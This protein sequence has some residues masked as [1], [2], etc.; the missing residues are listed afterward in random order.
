MKT[1]FNYIAKPYQALEH[2]SL[3]HKP[4]LWETKWLLAVTLSG[5]LSL[6]ALLLSV[7]SSSY[8]IL[9]LP[10]V[11]AIISAIAL[12]YW[13][14]KAIV[15]NGDTSNVFITR[16]T[17]RNQFLVYYGCI[18]S[19]ALPT[20][21]VIGLNSFEFVDSHNGEYTYWY[22]ED[23]NAINFFILKTIISGMLLAIL[24]QLVKGIGLKKILQAIAVYAI[25]WVALV[26]CWNLSIALG[27]LLFGLFATFSFIAFARV[28]TGSRNVSNFQFFLSFLAQILAPFICWV[29]FYGIV[30]TIML[31][32]DNLHYWTILWIAWS[33]GSIVY[34]GA[35]LP[36]FNWFY[37]K[38]RQQPEKD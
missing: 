21:L 14:T 16:S 2:R 6:V 11:F 34:V 4:W 3:I 20:F 13:V 36:R 29:F 9:S 32:Y 22:F 28:V 30:L 23:T 33:L 10:T 37:L 17:Y 26:L 24:I 27:V 5:S 18:L 1:I 15:Y 31:I 7:I 35:L 19:F 25:S 38:Y 12:G 8:Y